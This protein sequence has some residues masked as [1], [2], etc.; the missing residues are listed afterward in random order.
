MG[1]ESARGEFVWERWVRGG[2]VDMGVCA[3]EGEAVKKAVEPGE[4][5]D[6]G[7][8]LTKREYYPGGCVC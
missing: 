8:E 7:D 3:G 2:I 4:K 1:R 5:M 6:S